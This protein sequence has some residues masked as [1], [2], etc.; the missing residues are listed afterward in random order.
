MIIE[1]LKKFG[2]AKRKSI[3]NLIIPKLSAV[4]TDEQK[5]T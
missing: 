5:K 2:K 1:Y 4:L 3:E